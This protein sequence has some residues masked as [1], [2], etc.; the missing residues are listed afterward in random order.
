LKTGCAIEQ[1]QLQRAQGLLALLGLSWKSPFIFMDEGEACLMEDCWRIPVDDR[2]PLIPRTSNV[3]GGTWNQWSSEFANS[4]NVE[5]SG[6]QQH[7]PRRQ[8]FPEQANVGQFRNPF[9]IIVFGCQLGSFPT[10][11]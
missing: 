7:L 4:I 9:G 1:R 5:F 11:A 3:E 2:K 6:K 8:R 10:P